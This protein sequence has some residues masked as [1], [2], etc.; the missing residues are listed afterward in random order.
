MQAL[1][2]ASLGRIDPATGG[3]VFGKFDAPVLECCGTLRDCLSDPL[4]HDHFAIG[5]FLPDFGG[6]LIFR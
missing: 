6:H 2:V 3:T 5:D 1:D 4:D